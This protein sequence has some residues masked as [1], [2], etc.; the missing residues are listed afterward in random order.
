M[1]ALATYSGAYNVAADDPHWPITESLLRLVRERSIEAR[2][3]PVRVPDLGDE[4]RILA[5][6]GEYA[7]MCEGCHLGPGIAETEL[8]HGLNPKPPQLAHSREDPREAFW[9]IKHGIKATGMPA[10][11]RTHDDDLLWDLVAFVEKLPKLD[12][13][14]YRHLVAKAPAHDEMMENALAARL[15]AEHGQ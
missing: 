5:G 15:P 7:E 12:A 13:D 14:G 11:G 9:V 3:N 6:A 8:R 1:A 2:A 4:K 10:W